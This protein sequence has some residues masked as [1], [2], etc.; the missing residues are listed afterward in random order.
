MKDGVL[1][2]ALIF[3]TASRKVAATS[4]FA[5]LLKPM[6]LSLIWTKLRSAPAPKAFGAASET[7]LRVCDLR[8]PPVMVQRTP[9]PAQAM[10]LRKP[11]RSTPSLSWLCFIVSDILS[12]DL[13]FIGLFSRAAQ[14]RA[15]I[16]TYRPD[17]LN[18]PG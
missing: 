17:R 16:H 15:S 11:R 2:S 6:W 18:I 10:H 1:G 3:A 13:G 9:V 8:I 4:L 12:L 14:C 5:S 7:R